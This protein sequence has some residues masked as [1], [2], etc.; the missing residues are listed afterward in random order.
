MNRLR[1]TEVAA[2]RTQELRA[3]RY[4]CPLCNK[5]IRSEQ[6]ALDHCHTTGHVRAVLHINC[7]SIEGRVL[8]WARRSG[9]PPKDF[10]ES[11]VKYWEQDYT[12]NI[13][14]PNHLTDNEKRIKLLKRRLKKA[15][16]ESTRAR[17]REEIRS[18]K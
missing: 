10:L 18:L 9:I 15:K 11:L 1:P 4:M 17:L 14:H 6:A 12:T 16:R 5:N 13:L 3:Q 8:Q 2:H 7:N